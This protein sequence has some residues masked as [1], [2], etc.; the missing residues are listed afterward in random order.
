MS[1][2]EQLT[3]WR[4]QSAF[5]AVVE[6]HRGEL[7]VHCY[8]MTGS[9]EDA[10]DLV[11]ETLLRAWRGRAEFEGRSLFRTWLYRIATN[12][13]LNALERQPRRVLPNQLR[14]PAADPQLPLPPPSELPWLQPYPDALLE[15]LADG[16]AEPEEAAVARETMELAFLAVV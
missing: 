11:Q 2:A 7:Q 15:E 1:S 4:E 16:S 13:C 12:L 10:E 5:A 14:A 3:D 8:R 6:R 9:L